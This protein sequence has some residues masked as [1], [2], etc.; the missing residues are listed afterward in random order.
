MKETG[1]LPDFIIVGAMKSGTTSLFEYLCRHKDIF[2]CQP[3]EPM[4]FS[5]DDVYKYGEE[6]YRSQFAAAAPHQICGEASQSYSRWP[7]YPHALR[8]IAQ[9]IPDVKIIYLMRHP[10]DRVYSHY[11]HEMEQYQKTGKSILSFEQALAQ[12]KEYVDTSQYMC[13]I[14]QLLTHFSR[15]QCLFLALDDFQKDAI[16]VLYQ[17][18]EFLGVKPIDLLAA[19]SITANQTVGFLAAKHTLRRR[20]QSFRNFPIFS[21]F[22]N[23][24]PKSWRRGVRATIQEGLLKSSVGQ[25]LAANYKAQWSPFLPE[26]RQKLLKLFRKPTRELENFLRKDLSAWYE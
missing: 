15:E 18:Q 8:R 25:K 26:T 20:I 22:I 17:I 13:Q 12:T 5:H 24:M 19:G 14:S 11:T 6:W 4:F 23:C 16:G 9:L 3:K 10:V 1:R 7:H 2:M 21:S